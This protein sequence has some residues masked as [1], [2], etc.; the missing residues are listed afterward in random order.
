MTEQQVRVKQKEE[1]SEYNAGAYK[2]NRDASAEDLITKMPGITSENGTLKA[3]GE[4]VKKVTVDGK[5]FFGDDA[6]L[7]LKN[8]PSE[9]V[10]RV[11]VFD[12]MSDQARFTG[13]D[14]GNSQKGLTL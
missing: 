8:L 2:T 7:A 3:Q 14:D 11:Q 9:I 5:E 1:T 13:F 4:A 10:D 12:R 6:L